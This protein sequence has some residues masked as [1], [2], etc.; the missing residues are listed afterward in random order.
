M[1]NTWTTEHESESSG[2]SSTSVTWA[3]LVELEPRLENLLEVTRALC[4]R[5]ITAAR[6]EWIK[7]ELALLIGWDS[8]STD[9]R[10]HTADAWET[11]VGALLN[12]EKTSTLDRV[13]V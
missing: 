8:T 13:A 4:S 11:C 6:W 1:N 9:Q 2:S 12:P 7:L 10:L 5:G 3:E